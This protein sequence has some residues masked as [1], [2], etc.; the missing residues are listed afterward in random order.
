MRFGD[1]IYPP[2]EAEASEEAYE[3]L[4]AELRE[5]VVR[6]WEELRKRAR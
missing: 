3:E 1:P 5:H 4:T 2:P 6:M